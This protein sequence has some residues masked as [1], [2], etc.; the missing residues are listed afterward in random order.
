M[1]AL[2]LVGAIWGV[3]ALIVLMAA[4]AAVPPRDAREFGDAL[5]V[6]FGWPWYLGVAVWGLTVGHDIEADQ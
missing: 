5:R 1:G 3:I 4:L 6:G 2:Y